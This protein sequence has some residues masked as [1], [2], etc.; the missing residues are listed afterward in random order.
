MNVFNKYL[1]D[2]WSFQTKETHIQ[3]SHWS[4]ASTCLITDWSIQIQQ[5]MFMD[6][7][8]KVKPLIPLA[9]THLFGNWSINLAAFP[10]HRHGEGEPWMYLTR[11]CLITDQSFLPVVSS[12]YHNY[13][14]KPWMHL[15]S[16]CL[17]T[18]WSFQTKET[19]IQASH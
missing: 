8:L 6:N 12:P 13:Q 5:N 18:D 14:G 3:A 19:H 2:N 1:F 16:T 4:L 7:H 11:T 9:S 15:T 17:I 10:P